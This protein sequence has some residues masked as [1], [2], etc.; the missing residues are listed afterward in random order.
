MVK[1]QVTQELSTLIKM[2]RTQNHV[3]AKS[4]SLYIG[5]SISYI[6]KLESWQ[7]KSIP[8]PEL[9]KILSYIIP[10]DDFF[11]DKFPVIIQM[12]A[13][14]IDP[15][16]M[17]HQ[18]WLVHYEAFLRLISVPEQLI[19]NISNRLNKLHT[20]PRDFIERINESADFLYLKSLPENEVIESIYHDKKSLFIHFV[21]DVQ[22]WEDLL[23]QGTGTVCQSDLFRVIFQLYREELF[24]D[25][26]MND[27]IETVILDHTVSFLQ[28]YKLTPLVYSCFLPTPQELHESIF[29]M[30]KLYASDTASQISQQLLDLQ[31]AVQNSELGSVTAMDTLH[32]NLD[33]DP[34]F[35]LKILDLDFYKLG[36]MSFHLKKELLTEITALLDKY[37]NIPDLE[38]QLEQY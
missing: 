8:E 37:K 18:V 21:L 31:E 14:F 34:A 23:S 2:L 17:T 28:S 7:I 38:K 15:N 26:A 19:E 6:S 32:Y 20:T 13:S 10:G 11:D 22:K 24:P 27:S 33:W 1:F 29:D 12:L 5:K 36:N 16:E 9:T 35:T 4:L 3:T 30:K 25:K